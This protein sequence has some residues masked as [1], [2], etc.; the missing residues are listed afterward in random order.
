MSKTAAASVTAALV[1]CLTLSAC[2]VPVRDRVDTDALNA[3]IDQAIGGLDTCVLLLDTQTGRR[4][5]RYGRDTTCGQKLPPCETFEPAAAVIG[6]D[7][8]L[9][10]PQTVFKWDGAPQPSKLWQKDSNLAQAFHDANGWRFGHLSQQIGAARY[11]AALADFDYG[12]KTPVGPI[13]SFWQGPARG[14]GLYISTTGQAEFLHRLFSG[15]LKVKPDSVQAVQSVMT[16]ET[17]G[18][19]TMTAVAGSCS[20]QP[21]HS[22]GVAWWVGRLKSPS[23]DLVFAA[24][25]E[26]A[27]PPPGSDIGDNLKS[28]FADARLWPKARPAP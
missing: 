3:S 21:D 20:D 25:I 16:T 4:V 1:A 14:G 9:I 2:S 13:T 24:A 6:L 11:Q 22:R 7:A 26:A 28:I 19:A 12:N 5:Y 27:A 23:R 15:G 10:T 8:G 18:T 17:R